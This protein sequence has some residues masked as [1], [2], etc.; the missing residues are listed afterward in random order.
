MYIPVSSIKEKVIRG[1]YGGG[2]GSYLGR[3]ETFATVN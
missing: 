1:L 3:D 2:M